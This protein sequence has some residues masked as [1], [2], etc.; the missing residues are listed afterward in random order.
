MQATQRSHKLRFVPFTRGGRLALGA[1]FAH[2]TFLVM[3]MIAAASGQEGGDT[4]FDN[5]WLSIP[6]MLA[7][8]AIVVAALLALYAL[9]RRH[10]WSIVTVIVTLY[11]LL[12]MWFIAG[13]LLMPH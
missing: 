12:A 13:E 5:L 4:F 9:A 6:V 11:G 1:F 7:G 10:D 8:V 3:F 2:V